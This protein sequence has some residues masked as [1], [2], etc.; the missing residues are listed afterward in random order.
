MP[1]PHIFSKENNRVLGEKSKSV[2]A[3]ELIE[4]ELT[5]FMLDFKI[6]DLM[7]YWEDNRDLYKL[8]DCDEDTDPLVVKEKISHEDVNNVRAIA[9]FMLI[10]TI[11]EKH[12]GKLSSIVVKYRK[13]FKILQN[14]NNI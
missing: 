12:A 14:Y 9:Y 8:F 2:Q 5:K 13:L 11:A 4:K 7:K 1:I 3:E 10:Y 6:E